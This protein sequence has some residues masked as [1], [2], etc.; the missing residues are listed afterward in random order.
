MSTGFF[1]AFTIVSIT[2]CTLLTLVTI[3]L[4]TYS[5]STVFIKP[6]NTTNI[7]SSMQ[8]M[9]ITVTTSIKTTIMKQ[10]QP[11]TV[12]TTTTIDTRNATI[13]QS[14]ST[15]PSSSNAT[16]GGGGGIVPPPTTTTTTPSSSNATD[17]IACDPSLWNYIKNKGPDRFQRLSPECVAVQGTVTLV[18]HPPDGDTVFALKLDPQ[19]KNMVTKANFDNKNMKGGIWVELICQSKNVSTEAVHKGDCQGYKG[20]YFPTP[21][22]NE[23]WKVSGFHVIDIRE[24]GHAE[25][26]PTTSITR[27]R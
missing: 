18:H 27:I 15:T 5:Q 10:Q 8:G 7:T 26:H 11:Y 9:T 19:Y 4:P 21:K 20:P 2:I 23:R 12:T 25:I 13:S 17:T 24:G 14:P 22:V 3:S 6:N 1:L 16:G